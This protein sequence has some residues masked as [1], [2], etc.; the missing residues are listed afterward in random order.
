MPYLPNIFERQGGVE[1]GYDIYSRLLIDRIVFLQGQI[2]DESADAVVAQLLFLDSQ[3]PEKEISLYINSPGGSV[4]AGLAIYDTIKY[5]RPKVQAFCLGQAASMAAVI[6]SAGEKGSRFILPSGRVMLHQPWGGAEGQS[7]DLAITAKEIVRLKDLLIG[8]VAE[9]TGKK[10]G[11]IE[12]DM[13]RDFYLPAKEAVE[14]GV[15]DQIMQR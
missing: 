5:I 8:Y 6:L 3:D 7:R 10:H 4:T 1:R 13:D 9:N 14:Y 12:K 2:H 15:V 11:T